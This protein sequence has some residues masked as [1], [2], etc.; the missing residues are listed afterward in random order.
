MH[1]LSQQKEYHAHKWHNR[2]DILIGFILCLQK[3]EY[4]YVI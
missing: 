4:C 2:G 3:D 1:I